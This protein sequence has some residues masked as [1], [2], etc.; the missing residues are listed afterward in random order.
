MAIWL[1][2]NLLDQFPLF[3]D[4]TLSMRMLEAVLAPHA[5]FVAFLFILPTPL[6]EGSTFTF[7]GLFVSTS[8]SALLFAMS[9]KDMACKA[10]PARLL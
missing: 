6:I 1:Q 2:E 10:D 3:S 8:V 7:T 9:V 4:Y 5:L